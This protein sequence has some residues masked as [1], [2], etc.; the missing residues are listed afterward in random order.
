MASSKVPVR[1]LT[2]FGA[3]APW[4]FCRFGHGLNVSELEGVGG[5]NEPN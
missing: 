5:N 3:S 1:Q 2:D 4:I